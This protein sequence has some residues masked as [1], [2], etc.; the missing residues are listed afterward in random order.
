MVPEASR[1]QTIAYRCGAHPSATPFVT[2][3]FV[4]FC[5]MICWFVPAWL[6]TVFLRGLVEHR[7]CA[8]CRGL[9][10]AVCEGE[11]AIVLGLGGAFVVR[12]GGLQRG[13]PHPHFQFVRPMPTAEVCWFGT[14]CTNDQ[15]PRAH[16]QGKTVRSEIIC[17]FDRK[18]TNAQ[19]PFKH[20]NGKLSLQP[21]HAAAN[22]VCRFGRACTNDACV[23]LH[24][25]GKAAKP[26][27][28]HATNGAGPSAPKG[29]R[30]ANVVVAG[31]P[32]AAEAGP[33][34][35][36]CTPAIVTQ[37]TPRGLTLST[38]APAHDFRVSWTEAQIPPAAR[39]QYTGGTVTTVHVHKSKADVRLVLFAPLGG[40]RKA[41][42]CHNA[43]SDYDLF[44]KVEEVLLSSWSSLP[45]ASLFS[46]LRCVCA[47]PSPHPPHPRGG[48]HTPCV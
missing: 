37:V 39:A 47:R 40:K 46:P 41:C 21:A 28:P 8:G 32:R 42:V 12:G 44:H 34:E 5:V 36:I 18:C 48:A 7:V 22:V 3:T 10:S 45:I 17:K 14:N 20:P 31:K 9:S 33:S 27:R 19:C 13:H 6:G 11:G 43:A 1:Q 15:C 2:E 35:L 38:K 25:Q 16:P 30:G 24:P 29:P 23:F 4:G 26:P